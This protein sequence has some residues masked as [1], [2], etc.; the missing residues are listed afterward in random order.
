MKPNP[1]RA[2]PRYNVCSAAICPLE[3][4]WRLRVHNSNDR[5]CRMLTEH[6]KE[7]AEARFSELAHMGMMER[8]KEMM[9]DPALPRAILS[10][11]EVARHTGSMWEKGKRLHEARPS[12]AE[13]RAEAAEVSG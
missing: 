5:V 3:P 9:S 12:A 2:C 7:G 10:T 13:A 11:V 8:C 4:D 1:M 6:V